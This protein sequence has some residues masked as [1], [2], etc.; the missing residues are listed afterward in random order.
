MNRKTV[1]IGMVIVLAASVASAQLPRLY[2]GKATVDGVIGAKEW[3]KANWVR[4]D[5]PYYGT[6]LDV[7]NAMW[8]AM[9][10]AS[11]NAIYLAITATDTNHALTA[12]AEWNKQDD[13]EIYVT[14][15]NSDAMWYS[16]NMFA[17]AQ[18][19]MAGYDTNTASLWMIFGGGSNIPPNTIRAAAFGL[20][21]DNYVYEFKIRPF[22]HYDF[23]NVT[24]STEVSLQA[25]LV[26]GLDVVLSSPTT[27]NDCG[28]VCANKV[29]SKFALAG[30]FQDYQLRDAPNYTT[31]ITVR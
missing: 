29:T 7:T 2:S 20:T 28:M 5:Q 22:D 12:Y 31:I 3:S 13:V 10:D 14:A 24:N 21:G 19:Y 1:G 11:E 26:I 15:R 16:T 18:Q 27:T 30:A 9:W 4:M 6:V 25:K 17:E 23:Y 8:A